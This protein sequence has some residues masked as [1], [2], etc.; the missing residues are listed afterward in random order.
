MVS[1]MM[2]LTHLRIA[3]LEGGPGSE[4]DVSIRSGQNVA[5]W[6]LEAGARE[7]RRIEIRDENVIVPADVDLVFNMIHGTFGEDGQL[8][9]LLDKQGVLYTGAPAEPSRLSFD[10]ILSKRRFEERGIATPRYEVLRAGESPSL[11]LP[12]VVKAS[13]EGSSVGVYL[14]KEAAQLAPALRDVAP[15]GESF[16][17]E[18]LIDGRELTV[19][20]LGDEALPIIE[21]KPREGFYDFKNKY[22]WLNPAGAADHYCPAP[23]A[24]ELTARIQA[25]ALAAHRALDLEAYSRVDLML[26]AQDRPFVLEANTVPGMTESSLVPEAARVAGISPAQLC[27]RIVALSV[28]RYHRAR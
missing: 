14:V 24:P 15:Y 8:Q 23:L 11:P 13:R 4:R 6:L 16:L 17:V 19:G 3:V 26:D 25:L 27:A 21:I 20:I 12:L 10:K 22:P 2:N 18:E 28:E 9:A 1:L 5:Q 7:V